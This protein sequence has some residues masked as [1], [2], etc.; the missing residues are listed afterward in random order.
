MYGSHKGYANYNTTGFFFH[1]REDVEK[2]EFSLM[3]C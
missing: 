2:L 3:C 1:V